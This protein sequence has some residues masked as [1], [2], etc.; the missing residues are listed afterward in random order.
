MVV[1]SKYAVQPVF[2]PW[3]EDAIRA[4]RIQVDGK[5]VSPEYRVRASQTMTHYVH[6]CDCYC[7]CDYQMKLIALTAHTQYLSMSHCDSSLVAMLFLL[8]EPASSHL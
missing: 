1:M 2:L 5:N 6:R 7:V 8:S 3:Q 4:G